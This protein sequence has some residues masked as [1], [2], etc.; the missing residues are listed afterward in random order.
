MLDIW[1]V[2][3]FGVIGYFCNRVGLDNGAMALGI[4]LGPMIEE[5]FGKCASLSKA[6]GGSMLQVFWQSKIALLLI[7]LTLLSLLTPFFLE[8]KRRRMPVS[9]D[10]QHA[11]EEPH[12]RQHP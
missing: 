11:R 5:N 4:I 12:A 1:I 2:L 6:H 8:W 7:F 9:E 3:I 10:P